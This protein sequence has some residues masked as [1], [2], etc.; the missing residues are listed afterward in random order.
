MKLDN[1]EEDEQ[2]KLENDDGKKLFFF[3]YCPS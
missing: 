3:S 1:K 2:H